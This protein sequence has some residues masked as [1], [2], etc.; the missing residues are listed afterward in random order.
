MQKSEKSALSNSSS[1]LSQPKDMDIT[2]Y[3]ITPDLNRFSVLKQIIPAM[4]DKLTPV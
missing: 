2:Y 4:I 1:T 3:G